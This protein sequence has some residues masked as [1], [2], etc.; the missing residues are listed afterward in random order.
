MNLKPGDLCEVIDHPD[1]P[2]WQRH[3]I[4][5]KVILVDRAPDPP[6]C[7]LRRFIPYWHVS[8]GPRPNWYMSHVILRKIPPPAADLVDLDTKSELD[9]LLETY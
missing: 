2:D 8:G 7:G 1:L 9:E 3:T 6:F 4:G 5:L